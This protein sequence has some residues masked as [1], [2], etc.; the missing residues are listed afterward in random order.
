MRANANHYA[1]EG[2]AGNDHRDRYYRKKIDAPAT[3]LAAKELSDSEA[4]RQ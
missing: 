2:S 3:Q 1:P 4:G